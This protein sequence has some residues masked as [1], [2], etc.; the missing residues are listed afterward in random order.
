MILAF[1]TYYFENKAKTVCLEFAEWNDKIPS[2]IYSEIIEDVSEYESGAFYKRELPCILSLLK[3][4]KVDINT[5]IVVDGFVFLDDEFKPGLGAHLYNALEQHIP[6]IGVA[7]TN[8]AQI[9][10]LKKEVYRG[11]SR[12]PLYVTSVGVQVHEA[13]A[14]VQSMYGQYR[15][16]DLLKQLDSLTKEL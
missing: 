5:I 13:S 1:D 12:K 3:K 4:I 10:N 11:E 7:K 14:Y 8:F 16:P 9:Y 6:V 15:I 2:N